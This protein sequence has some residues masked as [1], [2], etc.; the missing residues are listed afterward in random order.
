LLYGTGRKFP[1]YDDLK[2]DHKELKFGIIPKNIY[3][4][5]YPRIKEFHRLLKNTGSIYLQ[6]SNEIDCYIRIIMNMVFGVNRFLSKIVCKRE[7]IQ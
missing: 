2:I 6:M 3:D 5:Y 7:R 1:D 4:F